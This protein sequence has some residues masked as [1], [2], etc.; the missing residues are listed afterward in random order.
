MVAIGS[1]TAR[2]RRRMRGG[3][4]DADGWTTVGGTRWRAKW[5]VS[6]HR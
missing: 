3:L 4:V 5:P 1:S 6:P 2:E